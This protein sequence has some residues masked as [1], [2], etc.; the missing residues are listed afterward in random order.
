[1]SIAPYTLRDV[2]I[3]GALDEIS[4]NFKIIIVD[5]DGNIIGDIPLSALQRTRVYE[6]TFEDGTTD[7][8][9]SNATQTVQNTEVYAGSYA[10]QMT[11]TAGQTGYV[12][13]PQRPVSPNQKVTFS[14][15]HKEDANITDV[16]L[17]V[18]WY[19][20]NGGV[21]SEDEYTL[22]PSTSWQIDSRTVTAPQNSTYM[23]LRIQATASS[24]A[25]GNVYIDDIAI[26]LVGQI[27]R[28]DGAGQIKVT[29]T[30]LYDEVKNKLQQALLTESALSYDNSSGTDT[31]DY[32][33][34]TSDITIDFNG[35]ITIQIIMNQSTTAQIK[36][37]P[38][39]QTT[40][41]TGYINDGSNINANSWYKFDMNVSNGDSINL[42]IQVPAGVTLNGYL[43]IFKRER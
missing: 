33:V 40:S 14:F 41:Y 9:V 10:L 18:V 15:A 43:R 1:M 16:K 31:V 8:T 28:V 21:I 29:D 12:E 20:A 27:F 22:T 5:S 42:V 37:T 19:R 6:Q 3:K 34:F 17:T 23:S 38:A 30:D 32:T 26:D 7:T 4:G 11:I 13:T 36:L 24:S 39:G 2:V 35:V 25:D